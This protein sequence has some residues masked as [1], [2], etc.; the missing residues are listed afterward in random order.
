MTHSKSFWAEAKRHSH[1]DIEKQ[2]KK[3]VLHLIQS[4][5]QHNCIC[6][7]STDALAD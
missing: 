3:S 2:L 1:G 7:V 4:S 6:V 5:S